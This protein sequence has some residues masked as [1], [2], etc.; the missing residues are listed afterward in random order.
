MLKNFR[1]L[2]VEDESDISE[3]VEL[4]LTS[5]VKELYM[6]TNGQEGLELYKEHRPDIVITDIQMPVMNGLEMVRAIRELSITVPVVIT[7][8][9]NDPNFLEEAIALNVD[10]YLTKPLNFFKFY[11]T[12]EK[13]TKPLLLTL[14]LQKKN[15]E[16]DKLLFD[17]TMQL[18]EER[19]ILETLFQESTDCIVMLENSSLIMINA[20]CETMFQYKNPQEYLN[21]HL[22]DLNYAPEYQADGQKSITVTNDAIET[23]I[24]EG[25]FRQE[26]L[27]QRK[28]KTL[29]WVDKVY[30]K[31]SYM[32]KTLINI[33]MRDITKRKELEEELTLLA[34]TDPLT[35]INNRRN[36]F[37]LA[38]KLL[39]NNSVENIYVLMIDIDNFKNVNDT[40]GHE[41][42][43]KVLKAIS[44]TIV[45]NIKEESIFGRLGGEEFGVVCTCPSDELVF[46]RVENLRK[47]IE[48]LNVTHQESVV[49]AT[50]S[51][52]ITKRTSTD[53]TLDNLLSQADTKLYEAKNSGKNRIRFR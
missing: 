48:N 22:N 27:C 36:F 25:S 39:K 42:G 47:K 23:C 20:A 45:S 1:I 12:L 44:H 28:D 33:S 31:L 21:V 32:S 24:K 15:R 8:A 50:V 35:N 52:G 51:I 11:E 6:A 19:N 3:E 46:K 5:R 53:Q 49:T 10:A 34:T 4:F 43:D 29:F 30:T 37:T 14:E 17:R 40:Y 9:Y 26:F 13:V 7:S 18:E 41:A 38:E 16:L 2:Y